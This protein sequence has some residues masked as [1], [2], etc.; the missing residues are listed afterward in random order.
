MPKNHT[1]T[2]KFN[3]GDPVF[4]EQER[5]LNSI[6]EA[7]WQRLYQLYKAIPRSGNGSE[8]MDS[9]PFRD[10]HTSLYDLKLIFDFDWTGWE[11]GWKNIN[12]KTFDFAGCSLLEL[13]MYLTA[14][15]RADRFCDG[16]IECRFKDGTLGKIFNALNQIHC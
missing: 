14:I 11:T 10:L 1:E 4:A 13:S 7:E 6:P 2:F 12:D 3:T 5:H 9:E 15:F 16:E 8:F